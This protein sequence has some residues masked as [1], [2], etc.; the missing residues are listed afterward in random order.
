MRCFALV[1][2]IARVGFEHPASGSSVP[3]STTRPQSS[4]KEVAVQRNSSSIRSYCRSGNIR[5]NLIFANIRELV[6]SRIQSS[7]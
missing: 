5:E 4:A 7:R 1:H 3:Q 2:Y 6:A